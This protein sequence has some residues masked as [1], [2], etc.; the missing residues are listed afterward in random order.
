MLPV[1]NL[2][3]EIQK[4]CKVKISH[5]L[6]HCN[7]LQNKINTIKNVLLDSERVGPLSST[8]STVNISPR[9]Y[10]EPATRLLPSYFPTCIF[11]FFIVLNAIIKF[12]KFCKFS[13][14]QK[15]HFFLYVRPRGDDIC[16]V[17]Y[18]IFFQAASRALLH[19]TLVESY[20]TKASFFSKSFS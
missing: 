10:Q 1:K 15:T 7:H 11:P 12:C 17:M 14:W 9:L 19:K 16:S 13:I 20:Q 6:E 8:P 3:H 4:R 18:L 5:L 2:E